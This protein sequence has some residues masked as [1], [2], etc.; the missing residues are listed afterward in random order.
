MAAC[1]CSVDVRLVGF[2]CNGKH[3]A[4]PRAANAVLLVPRE[5]EEIAISAMSQ[6]ADGWKAAYGAKEPASVFSVKRGVE[7]GKV[8]TLLFQ[9]V[10]FSLFMTAVNFMAHLSSFRCKMHNIAV[11]F[12]PRLCGHLKNQ[13]QFDLHLF[14]EHQDS[15][16][17]GRLQGVTC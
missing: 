15:S 16:I 13:L 7:Q 8:S 2:S 11:C 1:K 14:E 12:K 17:D 5:M 9:L 4:I 10:D 3:N 6:V